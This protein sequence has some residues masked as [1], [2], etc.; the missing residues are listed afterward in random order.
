MTYLVDFA[1]FMGIG[2]L[3]DRVAFSEMR[4][5]ASSFWPVECT[6][7]KA[8]LFPRILPL[9]VGAALS[10]YAA[11]PDMNAQNLIGLGL[12]VTPVLLLC[13]AIFRQWYAT[14]PRR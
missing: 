5:T 3:S 1:V 4:H 14:R 10:A 8:T 7:Y 9:P 2:L 6:T 13:V 12:M 11:G